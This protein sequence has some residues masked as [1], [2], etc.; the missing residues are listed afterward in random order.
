MDDGGRCGGG[1]A[2]S[3]TDARLAHGVFPGEAVLLLLP[4]AV[5]VRTVAAPVGLLAAIR[6]TIQGEEP[7]AAVHSADTMEKM[8]ADETA[9]QRTAV[10]IATLF[11][12]LA[13]LWPRLAFTVWSRMKWC[14]AHVNWP[15]TPHSAQARAGFSV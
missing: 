3:R 12:F 10:A 11:A 5:V 6:R 14:T 13:S 7:A 2:L 15:C 9:R 8:V 1:H 4:G